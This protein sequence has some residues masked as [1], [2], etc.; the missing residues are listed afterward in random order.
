MCAHLN[1]DGMGW[2]VHFPF[3]L[4][5]L[6]LDSSLTWPFDQLVIVHETRPAQRVVFHIYGPICCS[7]S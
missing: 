7:N 2:D 6:N 3:V 4:T 5:Y 1:G